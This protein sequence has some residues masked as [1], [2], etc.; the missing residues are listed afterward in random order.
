MDAFK[1]ILLLKFLIRLFSF[2]GHADFNYDY[3]GNPIYCYFGMKA[4]LGTWTSDDNF[5]RRFLAVATIRY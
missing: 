3:E 5:E 1:F 4:P 2:I